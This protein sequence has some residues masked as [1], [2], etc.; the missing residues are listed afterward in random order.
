MTVILSRFM[1]EAHAE[2]LVTSFHIV[3]TGC[4]FAFLATVILLS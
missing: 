2:Q 1:I 3:L 4:V